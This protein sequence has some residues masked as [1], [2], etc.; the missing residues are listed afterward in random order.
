MQGNAMQCNEMQRNVRRCKAN[1]SHEISHPLGVTCRG[2]VT[3]WQPSQIEP[4]WDSRFHPTCL[5]QVSR[6]TYYKPK[7]N[8]YWPIFRVATGHQMVSTLNRNSLNFLR[9]TPSIQWWYHP[10]CLPF[11]TGSCN[12]HCKHSHCFHLCKTCTHFGRWY[13]SSLKYRFKRLI[14]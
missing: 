9:F 3:S 5:L 11:S 13:N 2:K 14:S 4:D 10:Q 1:A 6:G 12:H 8:H 7:L